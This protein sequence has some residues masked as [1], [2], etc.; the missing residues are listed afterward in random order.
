MM[1]LPMVPKSKMNARP[2]AAL[3]GEI[4]V[5][6]P[7]PADWSQMTGDDRSRFCSTCQ[8]NVYN[9]SA[10]TAAEAAALIR[11]KEGKMCVRYYQ[12]A[13]GTMLTQDCPVGVTR[14]RRRVTRSVAASVV[15]FAA[16]ALATMD[17][18]RLSH[19]ER[20]LFMERIDVWAERFAPS[21]TT[22]DIA[23]EPTRVTMGAPIAVEPIR[24]VPQ[25]VMGA[26]API[27]P[28][29]G[30]IAVMGDVSV[31]PSISTTSQKSVHRVK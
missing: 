24:E 25:P 3:L 22:G 27:E 28:T 15:G 6:K 31:R 17:F 29:M 30:K 21:A 10:M 9:L 23:P 1:P 19:G 18:L 13:D 8:K 7:C 20:P 16:F 4:R 11:E 2:D 14:F 26:V 5:A 12:R